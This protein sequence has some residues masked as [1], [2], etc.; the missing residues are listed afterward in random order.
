MVLPRA[1]Y[2]RPDVVTIAR[3]LLGMTLHT[4]IAGDHVVAMIT[5]TEAYAGVGDRASHAFAGRRTARN[6]TMYGLGGHAYV[7]IC[8]GIHHMLNVVTHDE[9]IPHAVL[10]RGV[11]VLKGAEVA[12]Q[13][14]G[15][16]DASTAGPGSAAQA[17]GIRRAHDGT[18]L[19]GPTIR[20]EDDGVRHSPEAVLSGPRIGVGYAGADALLPYRFL[21]AKGS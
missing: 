16:P 12:A 4:C 17:M 15:R 21:L 18:D 14:R 5:E 11:R 2:L 20:I 10:I 19:L 7:Y 13:R 6:E 8:Y 9:G 1:F 3:D